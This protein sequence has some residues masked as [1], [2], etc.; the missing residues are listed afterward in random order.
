MERTIYASIF[1][2]LL[3]A[4]LLGSGAWLFQANR[5]ELKI[6]T[7]NNEHL[8]AVNK[9]K[10]EVINQERLNNETTQAL[11]S[12]HAAALSERDATISSL[13]RRIAASGGLSLPGQC[14]TTAGTPDSPSNSPT[15]QTSRCTVSEDASNALVTLAEQ[16]DTLSV[17]A[18]TCFGYVQEINKQRERMMKDE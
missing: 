1:S 10:Q 11:N 18:N 4:F 8:V 15:E 3:G 13:R 9:Q 5:Y 7:I 17:Y 6:E 16:A 2:F 14:K 12:K